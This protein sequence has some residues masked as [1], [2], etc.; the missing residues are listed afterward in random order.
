[1]K[2]RKE[3]FSLF[4]SLSHPSLIPSHHRNH[5]RIELESFPQTVVQLINHLPASFH[6]DRV[7]CRVRQTESRGLRDQHFLSYQGEVKNT[8]CSAKVWSVGRKIVCEAG[9]KQHKDELWAREKW[10]HTSHSSGKHCCG[11]NCGLRVNYGFFLWLGIEMSPACDVVITQRTAGQERPR[12]D[13]VF[14]IEF[15]QFAQTWAFRQQR[16]LWGYGC[17]FRLP[18]AGGKC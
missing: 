2:K 12:Q 1:M 4:P 18:K 11:Q 5:L 3:I 6:G 17:C 9:K 15:S 14:Q 16:I 13:E 8:T 7:I 10:C